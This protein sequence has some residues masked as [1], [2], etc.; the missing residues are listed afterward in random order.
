MGFLKLKIENLKLNICER[1]ERIK[2]AAPVIP[3]SH[4]P[5]RVRIEAGTQDNHRRGYPLHIYHTI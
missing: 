3:M 1:L 2:K 4:K 5:S